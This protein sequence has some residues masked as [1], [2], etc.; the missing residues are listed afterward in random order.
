VC[1]H[2]VSVIRDEV[3]KEI[4][5]GRLRLFVVWEPILS[6][7][8]EDALEDASEMLQDEWRAQQ[9]WDPGAESGKRI[10]RLFD[11]KIANPAWDVYMLYPPGT[12][13][14]ET[15]TPAY[16]MHQLTFLPGGEDEHRYGGLRLDAKKLREE[17][18]TRL[19]H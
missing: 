18:Q 9:F 14:T 11:L 1:L 17:I 19:K 12:K 2:G 13:W 4:P 8:G 3:M 7:D 10:R 6:K 16:W 5:D 15:P